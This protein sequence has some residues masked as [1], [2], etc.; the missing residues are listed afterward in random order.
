MEDLENK[1]RKAKV[2]LV[3]RKNEL[4]KV[5]KSSTARQAGVGTQNKELLEYIDELEE[6]I[7][8]L[9]M[10]VPPDEDAGSDDDN[11]RH[12]GDSDTQRPHVRHGRTWASQ[13]QEHEKED[14]DPKGNNFKTGGNPEIDVDSSDVD[15]YSD[16][17]EVGGSLSGRTLRTRRT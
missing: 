3:Q 2:N 15:S 6:K 4:E 10:E 8:R 11:D 5:K 17:V 9:T 14:D 7:T 13:P 12:N 1:L 16:D